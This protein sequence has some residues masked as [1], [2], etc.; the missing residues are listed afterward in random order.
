MT[1]E[2][3]A[4]DLRAM[5]NKTPEGKLLLEMGREYYDTES[6]ARRV[7]EFAVEK[8]AK[9]RKGKAEARKAAARLARSLQ[10]VTADLMALKRLVLR[11]VREARE[12]A[13]PVSHRAE[14]A[15]LAQWRADGGTGALEPATPLSP[16]EAL[17]HLIARERGLLVEVK[18]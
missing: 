3:R 8:I 9:E 13:W 4:Q 6:S 11:N 16:E 7:A 14:V 2:Q 18:S 5:Q 10:H 12:G 15:L 1:Y 17:D